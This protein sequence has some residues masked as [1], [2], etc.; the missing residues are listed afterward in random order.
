MPAVVT[1]LRKPCDS[2]IGS[3]ALAIESGSARM[4]RSMKTSAVARLAGVLISLSLR[5]LSIHHTGS[6][7]HP[8]PSEAATLAVAAPLALP[9]HRHVRYAAIGVGTLIPRATSGS[10]SVVAVR[11]SSGQTV[12]GQLFEVPD[13]V[14]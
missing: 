7:A 12:D 13:T 5:T 6:T 2:W 11:F 14:A 3:A 9:S 4:M 10:H 1:C 8:A